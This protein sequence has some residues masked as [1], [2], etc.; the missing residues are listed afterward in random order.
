MKF[1]NILSGHDIRLE[2]LE[3]NNTAHKYPIANMAIHA[4]FFYEPLA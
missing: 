2:Q 1:W 3:N 4:L